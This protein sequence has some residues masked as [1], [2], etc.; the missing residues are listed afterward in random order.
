[1]NVTL[2]WLAADLRA[3]GLDVREIDGWQTRARPGPFS[4]LGVLI[5]DTGVPTR[6]G[7]APS[8]QTCIDGRNDLP[9]PLCQLLIARS[10]AVYVIAGGRCNHAGE[11]AMPPTIPTN[12]GNSLLAGIELENTG[13]GTEPW[14]TAQVRAAQIATA[15]ILRK[16]GP[17]APTARVWGHR[18]YA[19]PRG[20]KPDPVGIDMT[21]FRG[22]VAALLNPPPS[23]EDD[24][25][26]LHQLGSAMDTMRTLYLTHRGT[27]PTLSEETAWAKDFEAKLARGEDLGPTYAWIIW[28]L[29]AEK[30][31]TRP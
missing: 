8:L 7:D 27:W 18:E 26:G 15:V 4:P 25:P 5:H 10:A 6:S 28:A 19:L 16:A 30:A 3:A 14:P 2:T 11:G 31:K 20:R 1:M 17:A 21:A 23:E 22:A 9:G 24:M 29:D 12:A 13:N